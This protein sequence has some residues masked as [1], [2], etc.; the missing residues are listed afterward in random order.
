MN[1]N[2]KDTLNKL[3]KRITDKKGKINPYVKKQIEVALE[4]LSK[5]NN[6]N[7]EISNLLHEAKQK[8]VNL[9]TEKT[10]DVSIMIAKKKVGKLK[11]DLLQLE[12]KIKGTSDSTE[13]S[14]L[15]LKAVSYAE[16]MEKFGKPKKKDIKFR[17]I[18]F[19]RL[20]LIDDDR[21]RKKL[22]DSRG[23]TDAADDTS[24][25]KIVKFEDKVTNGN[26]EQDLNDT[27]T[28]TKEH[29]EHKTNLSSSAPESTLRNASDKLSFLG[30]RLNEA[31]NNTL[32]K[33]DIDVGNVEN[34]MYEIVEANEDFAKKKI[35]LNDLL[36]HTK[37]IKKDTAVKEVKLKLTKIIKLLQGYYLVEGS[38]Y[39]RHKLEVLQ[40]YK[41]YA[42]NFGFSKN[43]KMYGIKRKEIKFLLK[44]LDCSADDNSL[45]KTRINIINVYI[46]EA[47]KCLEKKSDQNETTIYVINTLSTMKQ[48]ITDN[49]EHTIAKLQA[50]SDYRKQIQEVEDFSFR[51][52]ELKRTILEQL[53]QYEIE[54]Y[55]KLFPDIVSTIEGNLR[56]YELLTRQLSSLRPKEKHLTNEEITNGKSSMMEM[57]KQ[58]EDLQL[59]FSSFFDQMEQLKIERDKLDELIEEIDNIRFELEEISKSNISSREKDE[60]LSTVETRVNLLFRNTTREDLMQEILDLELLIKIEKTKVHVDN[61]VVLS[62]NELS[63]R[64]KNS[65]HFM[66]TVQDI[67]I[68][69]EQI[70]DFPEGNADLDSQKASVSQKLHSLLGKMD[71]RLADFAFKKRKTEN[72][73]NLNNYFT[74]LEFDGISDKESVEFVRK[75]HSFAKT[76]ETVI[77]GFLGSR[78]SVDYYIIDENLSRCLDKLDELICEDDVLLNETVEAMSYIKGLK[79]KLRGNSFSSD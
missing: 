9:P 11:K 7:E 39:L 4:V 62:V 24:N 57:I 16:C 66:E 60:K 77:Q 5:R 38:K 65:H 49:D 29:Y 37:E 73:V 74:K 10:E 20:F 69:K 32:Q 52:V 2:I 63:E 56:N 34:K 46:R 70:E 31:D 59:L 68:L 14:E 13:R 54:I 8:L 79:S 17:A 61:T 76:F 12:G 53:H 28:E 78:N 26:P 1:E 45:F 41:S 6:G 40:D 30:G 67:L 36:E 75:I 48:N 42:Q 21:I 25:R 18:L 33:V 3:V 51:V 72:V 44:T 35:S 15:M 64:I 43:N 55:N 22:I 47:L 27:S 19:L 23:N 71:Q 50:L 58:N